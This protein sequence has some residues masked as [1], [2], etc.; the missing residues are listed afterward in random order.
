M[1]EEG[2]E[3]QQAAR[4]PPESLEF[5]TAQARGMWLP[6]LKPLGAVQSQSGSVSPG[7]TVATGFECLQPM[8]KSLS[9]GWCVYLRTLKPGPLSPVQVSCSPCFGDSCLV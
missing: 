4:E 6:S 8:W 1:D 9:P 5:W 7:V 2:E 3:R